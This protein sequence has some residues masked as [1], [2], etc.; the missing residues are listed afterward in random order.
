MLNENT[1]YDTVAQ[2]LYNFYRKPSWPAFYNMKKVERDYWRAQ[3]Q[4]CIEGNFWPTVQVK[5]Q[6]SVQKRKKKGK[7]KNET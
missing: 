1:A 6:A 2:Y 7:K 3:A 4:I 5:A